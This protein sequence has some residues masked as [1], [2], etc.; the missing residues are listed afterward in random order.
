[1]TYSQVQGSVVHSEQSVRE[2]MSF[3]CPI[4]VD[5]QLISNSAK[6]LYSSRQKQIKAHDRRL[7]GKASL[8]LMRYEHKF[9]HLDLSL[10]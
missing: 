2:S 3:S 8:K 7:R 5:S 6:L 1:M 4:Y 9:M 10:R